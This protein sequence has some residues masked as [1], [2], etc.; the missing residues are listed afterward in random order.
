MR[1]R[2][3]K[4]W[5]IWSS[6]RSNWAINQA[7]LEKNNV[8]NKNFSQKI[9]LFKNKIVSLQQFFGV[10]IRITNAAKI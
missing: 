9:C 2:E 10:N 4:L 7:F 1:C 5:I 8:E 3:T 6:V